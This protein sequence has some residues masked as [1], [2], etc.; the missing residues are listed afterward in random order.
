LNAAGLDPT[1]EASI[2]ELIASGDHRAALERA[3]AAHK[4]CRTAASETLLVDA[5]AERIRSL[6]HRN[7]TVEANSL[8]DLVRQRYPSARRRLDGLIAP[9]AERRTSL[10]DVVRPLNDPDLA[11]ERR[12]GIEQTIKRE[13]DDLAALARCDALACDHPLRRAAAALEA[14]F[15]AVT[16]GPVAKEALAL[17]EISHRS[18]LAPWK[19]LVRAIGSFYSG[20]EEACRRHLAAIDAESAPARLVP[21][22]QT[23]LG[24]R[25]ATLTSAAAEL[26]AQII[27]PSTFTSALRTLDQAFVAGKRGPILKAIRAAVQ[28]CKGSSPRQLEALKQRISV[29]CAMLEL[30]VPKVAAAVGSSS[31]HDATF[32]RLLA[33]GFEETR[34]PEHVILACKVWEDFRRAAVQEGWFAGNGPESAALALR[35]AHLAGELPTHILDEL[36]S[37]AIARGSTSGEKTMVPDPDELYCRA[38]VLDPHREAFAQWMEWASRSHSSGVERAASVWHQARPRDTEP[39]LRLLQAA[40]ARAALPTALGFLAKLEQIDP[41]LAAIRGTRFRLLAGALLRHIKDKKTSLAE[42]DLVA[43]GALPDAQQGDRPAFGLAARVLLAAVRDRPDEA[44]SARVELEQLLGPTATALLFFAVATTSKQRAL[45]RLPPPSR[46]LERDG[47]CVP[48]AVARVSLL[49]SELKL[50]FEL[51]WSW[52]REAADQFARAC[53]RLEVDALSALG[54]LALASHHDHFAYAISAAGLE[55]GGTSEARFLL[56]R[57]RSVANDLTRFVVCAKAATELARHVHDIGL[58]EQSVELIR[59]LSEFETVSV[60]L[61]QARDVLAREKAAREPPSRNGRSPDYRDLVVLCQCASCRRARGEIVDPFDDD[62]DTGDDDL[63]D[64]DLPAE[65]PPDMPP[66]VAALLL[67]EVK[68]AVRRGES[69]EQFK[70]RMFEGMLPRK[71]RKRRLRE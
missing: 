43:I 66:E 34:D 24:D 40:E 47:L 68:K 70:A 31:L 71:R 10:N 48:E 39:L 65:L 21:A 12:A 59:E 33:R 54:D 17:P 46:Q 4:S 36:R 25:V 9:V 14:A 1:T 51:P 62:L 37:M 50:K 69:F 26:R 8:M 53:H 41:E 7:L 29:R 52:I 67:E 18:A 63:E 57:G 19:S 49:S 61:A 45:A 64:L 3:K 30:D 42:S 13:I 58:V 56:L 32:L 22:V 6:L 38:C 27:R 35:I 28:E 16:S 11:G 5:Y 15:V 23:M 44:A 60:T 2:R 55:R 20:D